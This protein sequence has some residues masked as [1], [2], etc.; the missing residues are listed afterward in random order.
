MIL[1][2]IVGRKSELGNIKV[3]E[4]A[5]VAMSVTLVHE[6]EQG[7][8]SLVIPSVLGWDFHKYKVG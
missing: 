6:D 4:E 8:E 2:F 1:D 5:L 3:L 7:S